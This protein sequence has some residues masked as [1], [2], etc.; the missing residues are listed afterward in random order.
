MEPQ[1]KPLYSDIVRRNNSA[2]EADDS[3]DIRNSGNCIIIWWCLLSAFSRHSAK[4]KCDVMRSYIEIPVLDDN[5]ALS[6]LEALPRE[7]RWRI[8]EYA[9]ECVHFLRLVSGHLNVNLTMGHL[10][11]FETV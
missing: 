3:E 6:T 4:I 9:S 11:H 2:V 10:M 5:H 8:V 1:A 7:L